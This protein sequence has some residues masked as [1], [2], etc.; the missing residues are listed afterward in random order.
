MF[1]SAVCYGSAAALCIVFGFLFHD[2]QVIWTVGAI[3]G[4]LATGLGALTA[5]TIE[6]YKT[7]ERC[8]MLGL[9]VSCGLIGSLIGSPLFAILPVSSC[10]AAAAI[11]TIS[12]LISLVSSVLLKDPS[13]L[14]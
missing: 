13:S 9:L 7:S 8:S 5:L 3:Q 12:T 1:V 2:N 14:I 4:L 6:Y 10:K 11:G